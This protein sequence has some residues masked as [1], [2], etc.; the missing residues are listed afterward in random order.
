KMPQATALAIDENGWLH[1][2]DLARRT[3]EGYYKITGRIKDMIIRGGENIYPKEI[4]DFIYTHPK[5]KDV[6]VIGVPDEQ[7]GEEIM[8]CIILKE[9]ET[10]TE[11]EI[12]TYVKE[13]MAKHKTPRYVSFVKEFPMNAAGK[14]LKYKMR[15]NAVEELGL[16]KA[17]SIVT[18]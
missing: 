13:H 12:K 9:N 14:I 6:Q 8:A 17:A 16:K 11:E 7:Y 10:S 4:E 18:A 15:E 3:P 1:T 5:V 2:G